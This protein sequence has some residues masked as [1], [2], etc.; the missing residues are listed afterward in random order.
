MAENNDTLR[1][2]SAANEIL[3]ILDDDPSDDVP[4]A[5]L[6]GANYAGA[7]QESP[8]PR[9]N[10]DDTAVEDEADT[11]IDPPPSWKADAKRRFRDLP[12]DLQRV[13]ADRERERE[14]HFSRT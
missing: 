1:M 12:R 3:S 8:E 14:T 4:S 9:G 10:G 7:G 13:I 5:K 2:D 6:E 11:P